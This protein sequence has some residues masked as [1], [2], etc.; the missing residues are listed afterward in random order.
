MKKEKLSK[1][2]V[3][4]FNVKVSEQNPFSIAFLTPK[5]KL[6]IENNVIIICNN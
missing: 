2:N 6:I 3:I 4:A 5:K 1:E